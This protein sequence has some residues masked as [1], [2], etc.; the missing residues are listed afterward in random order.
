M[1][2]QQQYDNRYNFIVQLKGG[3]LFPGFTL[4]L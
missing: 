3:V 2:M 1:D 4:K